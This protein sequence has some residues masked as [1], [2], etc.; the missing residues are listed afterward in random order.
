[1]DRWTVGG[2]GGAQRLAPAFPVDPGGTQGHYG[3]LQVLADVI[4]AQDCPRSVG[5]WAGRGGKAQLQELPVEPR[6]GPAPLS[7]TLYSP[8]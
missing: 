8:G 5:P 7:H 6:C 3:Y 4:T 2:W 1:M